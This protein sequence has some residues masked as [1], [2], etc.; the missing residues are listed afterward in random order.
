MA[1][2]L[3]PLARAIMRAVPELEEDAATLVAEAVLE[4]L[5]GQK[6]TRAV[7]RDL[8]EIRKSSPDVAK[9]GQAAAALALALQLD[10][11]WNSA[12]SKAMCA[13][14]LHEALEELRGLT[15]PE[16]KRDGI[17]AARDSHARRRRGA[18]TAHLRGS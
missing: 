14:A 11:P 13:R 8:R 1:V 2:T 15:P 6:V 4:Q 16:R 3:H 18:D 5:G 12:T 9:G 17:D 10:F 7:E